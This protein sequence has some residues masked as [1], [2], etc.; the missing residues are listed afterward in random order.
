MAA[1]DK[2]DGLLGAV[3]DVTDPEPLPAGHPLFS[4]PRVILT[5]HTS[6]SVENYF[7]VGADVL[8]SQAK[9]LKEGKGL[10]NVVDP[11]KGY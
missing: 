9:A 4:H 8:I 7:D 11:A 1:L 2:K 10:L 5:P 6:G 3:L